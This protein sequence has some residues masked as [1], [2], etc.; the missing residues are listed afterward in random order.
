M[1]SN[2]KNNIIFEKVFILGGTSEIAQEICTKLV[3]SGTKE[4][5]LVC[6]NVEKVSLFIKNLS[7]EFK[8]KISLEKLDMLDYN[9]TIKPKINFYNLYIIA[10]GYLGNSIIASDNPYEA[11]KIARV[12]YYSLIPWINSI[13]SENRISKPG[14]IWILSSVAGD[15][16]R[17]SNFHYGAAK[18]ALTIFCEGIFHRCLEKPFKVRI[19]KIGIIRTSMSNKNIP[20]ILSVSKNY[21]AN[22][23]IRKPLNEGIEYL[24]WWWFVIMKIINILPKSLIS[25][26]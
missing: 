17:P 1:K 21:L 20:K 19:I 23:L 10:T 14:S 7:K 15:K 11:Y 5:H 9:L 18:A 2:K 6:R 13:T 4:I 12:N 25:K 16:G 3:E 22:K 24:P 26:L 8:I